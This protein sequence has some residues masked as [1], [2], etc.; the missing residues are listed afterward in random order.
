MAHNYVLAWDPDGKLPE[1]KIVPND[2]RYY[3]AL[4]RGCVLLPVAPEETKVSLSPWAKFSF[5]DGEPTDEVAR[6][7]GR[8]ALYLEPGRGHVAWA[9]L[10]R[11]PVGAER[12][13]LVRLIGSPHQAPLTQAP[14]GSDPSGG[15]ELA[16]AELFGDTYVVAAGQIICQVVSPGV[17]AFAL[18]GW[19]RACRLAWLALSQLP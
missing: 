4:R 1:G 7:V 10:L 11:H 9:G 8:G 3:E 2:E 19:A 5:G 15:V 18:Y 12:K 17:Y 6:Y 16:R 14:A 13:G